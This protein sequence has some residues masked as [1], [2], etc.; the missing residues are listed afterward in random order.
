MFKLGT[1][2]DL[3]YSYSSIKEPVSHN[4]WSTTYVTTYVSTKE[5][6]SHFVTRWPTYCVT[7][8][9]RWLRPEFYNVTATT[10]KV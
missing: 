4:R 7:I 5:P 1:F 8:N 3:S 9:C 10:K 2:L 6:V